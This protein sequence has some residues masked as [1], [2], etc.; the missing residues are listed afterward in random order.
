MSRR[1]H[2]PSGVPCC[3]ETLQPDLLDALRFYGDLFGWTFD[4]PMTG[5]RGHRRSAAR[6]GELVVSK[7]EQ[8]PASLSTAAW[9]TY[10]AVDALDDALRCATEAG[11]RLLAE[12]A[13]AG[14]GERTAII[15]DPE[16]VALGLR[17]AGGHA[18][19]ELVNQPGAWTM[20]AL[21]T[22]DTE[23]AA[24]FYHS[25]FG[26]ELEESTTMPVALWRRSGYVGADT[27][28]GLPRDLVAVMVATDVTVVP[29]HWAINIRVADV[30]DVL[31]RAR[32]LGATVRSPK[33]W[34][35]SLTT[36]EPSLLDAAAGACWTECWPSA[37]DGPETRGVPPAQHLSAANHFAGEQLI[38]PFS[39]R[40]R[41]DD[42][43]GTISALTGGP[44][45]STA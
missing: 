3:I 38:D 30:D 5:P 43:L 1:T 6:L 10:I 27:S 42:K 11:G 33:Q 9:L 44:P 41:V 37:Y 20:S 14:D 13:L 19:A 16:G 34:R 39:P 24:A 31:Q 4:E 45:R 18:G 17:Q 12:P 7:I 25:L 2:Y 29:A 28:P 26:W 40:G 36:T 23:R 35:T 15:A 32:S 8:A 21:H 22:A